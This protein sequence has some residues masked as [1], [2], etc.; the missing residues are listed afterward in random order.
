[1]NSVSHTHSY[2]PILAHLAKEKGT[3]RANKS[4][5]TPSSTQF[6][7]YSI[8]YGLRR[9]YVSPVV[10]SENHLNLLSREQFLIK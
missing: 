10:I 7:L 6:V 4:I 1:M 3:A 8:K 5:L 9:A 2:E